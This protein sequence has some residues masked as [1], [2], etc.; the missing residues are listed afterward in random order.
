MKRISNFFLVLALLPIFAIQIVNPETAA[1][2]TCAAGAA[3]QNNIE[4]EP[5]HGKVLYIDTGV[6]P[7][8]DGAYIGYRVKNTTGATISGWWVSLTNF[9]GGVV[10]LA[11]TSDKYMQLPTITNGSTKTVYFLLKATTSTKVAQTHTVT[12]YNGRPDVSGSDS[13]YACDF[14]FTKVAETI[15]A[16]AN[17]VT[18]ITIDNSTPAIG[19]LVSVTVKGATGTIGAGSADVGKILW[20]S[21]SAFA[22]FPTAAVRL[23]S[24]LLQ[25]GDNQSVSASGSNKAWTYSERLLVTSSITP[26]TGIISGSETTAD[27]LDSKRYYENVYKF[28]ILNRTAS[29][30]TFSPVAQIS[31]GTQI[32]HTDLSQTPSSTLT[33]T[34]APTNL[35]VTKSVTS[36]SGLTTASCGGSTC[37][38]VPYR[39]RL[40]ASSG[41]IT[42]DEVVDTPGSGV[43][44]KS[45][46]VA[47]SSG[48][49]S[50]PVQLTSESSL[51]PQPYHFIGPFTVTSGTNLDITY[52]M[53]VPQTANATYTNNAVAY[54]G[55]L[56]IGASASTISNVTV[57]NN[58]SGGVSTATSGTITIDPIA[59]TYGATSVT[60]S[61]ATLNGTVDAN[62][63]TPSAQFEWST[64]AN[65]AT[66][67]TVSLS[68]SVSGS[69]PTAFTS[70]FTGTAG[71]TY[72]YRIVAIK[73]GV[74]YEGSIVSFTVIE[75]AT[76]SVATTN[77]A[78]SILTQSAT[79]NGSIDPNL[80]TITEVRFVYGRASD[81][82]GTPTSKIL[83]ELNED[84]TESATKVTLTGANPID[85]SYV[86]PAGSLLTSTAYY[87]RIEGDYT[88]GTLQTVR[89][90]ILSFKTGT[91]SQT[92]TF[93][94]IGSKTF[95]SGTY[96]ATASASSNLAI[97]YTSENTDIC[98][99]DASTGVITFVKAGFC[100]ITASQPGDTTYAAAEPV[101]QQFEITPSAPTATTQ[102]ASSVSKNGAV[103]N[104]TVTTG[105]GGS[106]TTTFQWG[107]DS[108]LSGASTVTAAQ[109]PR[110]TDGAG[111]YT[112]SGLIAGT[113]Y[114]FR[115]IGT[116]ST[117]TANGSILNFT[118]TA[119]SAITL[120]ADDKSKNYGATTPAFTYTITSG[121]LDGGDTITALTYTFANLDANTP[122][123]GPTS[124]VPTEAGSYSITISAATFDPSPAGNYTVTYT[125]GTY[126][127]NKI[128]QSA[129]S[130]GDRTLSQSTTYTLLATGGSG[131]GAVSYVQSSNTFASGNC[132]IA[133]TDQLTTPAENGTCTITATKAAD[134]NYNQATANGLMTINSNQAQTITFPTISDR[135]FSAT[136]FI[137]SST[138]ASSTLD[139][140]LTSNTTSVCTVNSPVNSGTAPTITMVTAGT[141]SITASQGGGTVSSNTFNA[142][143]PVTRTF[144]INKLNQI[145]NFPA[146]SDKLTSDSDV[147]LPATTDANVNITYTTNDSSICTITGSAGSY[148]IHI[149]GV[150]TC[151]VTASAGATSIYNAATD[152][153]RSFNITTPSSGNSGS[154]GGGGVTAPTPRT[155]T[156]PTVTSISAPEVCAIG[157]QLV[158]KGTNLNG[159]TATLDGDSIRVI[160]S[161]FHEMVVALPMAFEGVRAIKVTN[162]DGSA[163]TTVK[164][165][166]VDTPIY[167]N[168]I[169]P[170]TF[171]DLAFSY[172]FKATD[173]EKYAIQ[174]KMPAGL[175]LNPLTGELSG[176]PTEEGDFI[177][178][179]VASNIC[180]STTLIVY[181]FVDKAIPD[182]YTCSV[183][184]NVPSSNNISDIKLSAL[185]TCLDKMVKLSPKYI[186]PVIFLSGGVPMTLSAEEQLAHPRYAQIVDFIRAQ[187]I[188]SQ[189]YVGAFEGPL[190]QVQLNFYW[191]VT[192]DV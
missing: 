58:S 191:P 143:S 41:T 175:T 155:P 156:P 127:I 42:I 130:L 47:I 88:S 26:D 67:T 154:G 166:F 80:Q 75:N 24:V 183:T 162:S 50:A 132:S 117:G 29:N 146:I 107:T 49:I 17:K 136:P 109:S 170:E 12:V 18:S 40:S 119:S 178:N 83:Y 158:I 159:A 114:Y 187:G 91:T 151:T 65:L 131:T 169:Y 96:T 16:A 116:N 129:L 153:I 105:G 34:S 167:V 48:S 150:G 13:K 43:T 46:S 20:F 182:S 177:F 110:T 184:F 56:K 8:I 144:V 93:G 54:I 44:Y 38:V 147:D 84:G 142:A 3:A 188:T 89:G 7:R 165:R 181:M 90:S 97:T 126:T 138:T 37:N 122:A 66:Y 118:T 134:R 25:I 53:L 85:L 27:T 123:Y 59:V 30:L 19:Q 192:F 57:T 82:S 180:A 104:G 102:A 61:G 108:G 149:V 101:T 72:Y 186:D 86:I 51:N 1:A 113:T 79:L 137:H 64:N 60:S 94:A 87:F 6:S 78:T 45:G 22:N 174:G 135:N 52:Q 62:G 172:T 10:E 190:D 103:I 100:L 112:L 70:A 11:N 4:V 33:L 141:C 31:S 121:S 115:I 35:T 71:T 161:S 95:A 68:A 185:K 179:I 5:S 139:V 69:D 173:A 160:S 14:S 2:A 189:I 63:Q 152:V 164:Y 124:T 81:L 171:K 39:I 76:A 176:T 148:K 77:I 23:E 157:D 74:R 125:T 120:D 163:S 55:T 21:P 28:R 99:V 145:I 32:K 168:Y 133:S 9:S 106:T 36:T 15:K 73:S 98:T 92:I 140:T 128:N 111:S